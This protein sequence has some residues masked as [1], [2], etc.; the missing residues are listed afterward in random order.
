MAAGKCRVVT[1]HC[2][3][4][5]VLWNHRLYVV[6]FLG[7]KKKKKFRSFAEA[8]MF[9]MQAMLPEDFQFFSH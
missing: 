9:A 6:Y 1:H 8:E 3:I 2:V 5:L 7:K 4:F